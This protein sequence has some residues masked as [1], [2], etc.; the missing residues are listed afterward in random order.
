MPLKLIVTSYIQAFLVK[1]SKC[2]EDQDFVAQSQEGAVDWEI[3]KAAATALRANGEEVNLREI[4]RGSGLALE[5]PRKREVSPEF[6]EELEVRRKAAEQRA[7]D[8]L[9][10]DVTG[11]ETKSRMHSEYLPTMKLQMSQGVHIAVTMGLGYALGSQFGAALSTQNPLMKPLGGVVGLIIALV[12]ETTLFIVR[13]NMASE[14]GMKYMHLLDP[15]RAKLAA[16]EPTPAGEA[17]TT[18]PV[19]KIAEGSSKKNR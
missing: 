5:A 14:G 13:A 2:S 15:K 10:E 6:K 4:C 16:A 1:A 11:A 17:F 12:F 18:M 8:A 19:P 9:V 7:Y 3:I